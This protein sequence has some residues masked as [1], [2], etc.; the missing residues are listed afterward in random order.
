MK[1]AITGEKGFLGIQL[2]N[3]FR[4]ILKYDVIE[5]GKNYIEKL[6]EI[7]ELDWL[8]HGACVHR[9]ENLDQVLVLNTEITN[10]TLD[11]LN[12]NNIN[13]NI[14]F[15]S[16]IQEEDETT[17]GQSKREAKEAFRN[18]CLRRNTKFVPFKLPNTFGKYARPYRTSFIAT[19]CYNLHN[20]ISVNYNKNKVKLCYI[21]EVVKVI[22][23][24]EEK[25]I[26]FTE[27][28]VDEVY[29]IL[30]KFK[31]VTLNNEFPELKTKFELNLYQTYLHY[32][33]YK[34]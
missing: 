20:N 32:V 7:D 19:F 13:C 34:L 28:A 31:E 24:L 8:I 23:K 11:C 21:D 3:Y 10:T 25:E 27:T 6:K 33:N 18:Y 9:N 4:H 1:I 30:L 12:K 15:L 2:T 14:V 16:T 17:Y 26:P 22:S 5:L 29:F